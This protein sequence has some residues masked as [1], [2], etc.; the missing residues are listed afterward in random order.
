MVHDALGAVQGACDEGQA[1]AGE[2]GRD[3]AG[4]AD[5]IE[6]TEP[7]DAGGVEWVQGQIKVTGGGVQ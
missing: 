6:Y 4:E 5:L 2:E 1:E 7:H 3:R